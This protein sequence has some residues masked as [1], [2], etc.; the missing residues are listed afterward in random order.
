M[1]YLV[2]MI[3]ITQIDN[4]LVPINP[5]AL[6]QLISVQKHSNE[7]L[8]DIFTCDLGSHSLSHISKWFIWFIMVL[9]VPYF[10]ID[11]RHWLKTSYFCILC[12]FTAIDMVVGCV[13]FKLMWPSISDIFRNLRKRTH[14]SHCYQTGFFK[15]W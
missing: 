4:K 6:H 9:M 5:I 3:S 11:I 13:Y 2:V 12:F 10:V 14:V 15:T 1:K 7:D 8:E